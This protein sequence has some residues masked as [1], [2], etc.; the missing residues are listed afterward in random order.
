MKIVI[1]V[2]TYWGR[3]KGEPFC[4]EDDVYDHPT[5]LDGESTLPRLLKSLNVIKGYE[6]EVL[7]LAVSTHPSFEKE[8]EERCRS[9]IKPFEKE[10]PI[11]LFSYSSLH[12]LWE[13]IPSEFRRLLSLSGYSNVRNLCLLIPF[14]MGAEVIVFLDD[15]EEVRDEEFLHKAL[16]QIGK[17]FEGETVLAKAG[18]YL[19][20]EWDNYR[21]PEAKN[22][23]EAV[24]GGVKAMNK[25]FDLI[26][27]PS[28]LKK[29]PFVFGGNMVVH[30][31]LVTQVCFD[32]EISRGEDID[33]LFNAKLF[34]VNFFLD[35][36]LWIKHLPPSSHNP[37]WLAFR[38][39]AL[40]FTYMKKK[41]ESQNGK[42]GIRKVSLEELDPYPG[43]FLR[44]DLF[45]RIYRYSMLQAMEY[46]RKGDEVGYKESLEN[47]TLAQFPPF[48]D[49]PLAKYL[50]FRAKWR[51]LIKQLILSEVK[52]DDFLESR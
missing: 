33:F 42:Q 22:P 1:A 44:D 16:Y 31:D 6:F 35:N 8:A 29:T 3:P 11:S 37:A 34:G 20:P 26:E 36:E 45:E 40:R 30:R 46:L 39:N 7:V 47:I 48:S 13:L 23:F 9:V 17:P 32:P 51:K 41:F 28:R 24:W 50:D 19:R 2:P 21:I 38:Q 4:K 27:S 43:A 5:P 18:F 49:D 12:S 10:L 25:A 14:L 52:A 15:D